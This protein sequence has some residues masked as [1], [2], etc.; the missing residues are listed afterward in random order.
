LRVGLEKSRNLMTVRVAQ[1]IG[2][3]K[4]A[5]MAK[6]LGV[7]DDLQAVLAMALGAGE[8]TVLRPDKRLCPDRHG[9]KKVTPTLIDR[10]QDKAGPYHFPPRRSALRGCGDVAWNSQPPPTIPDTRQQVLDPATAY[11][12]VS[13]LQGVVQRG[14]GA[15]VGTLGRPLAG[16]T[17]TTNDS[18]DV[19]LSAFRPISRRLL[20]GL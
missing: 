10:V 14:T 9:G 13:M 3:T 5:E 7:V 2:M 18:N 17:G 19:W 12:M 15:I 20:H 16:K 4:V 11:Q 8:T 6:R 1:A